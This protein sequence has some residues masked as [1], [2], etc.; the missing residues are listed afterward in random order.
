MNIGHNAFAGTAIYNDPNNWQS[1]VLYIDNCLIKAQNDLPNNYQIHSDTRLIAD[2]AFDSCQLMQSITIPKSV[3]RIGANAFNACSSLTS[4]TLPCG[5]S[6]VGQDA[7]ASCHAL[8][9]ITLN[10]ETLQEYLDSEVNP[11]LISMNITCPRQLKI[12]GSLVTDLVLPDGIR[13]V[14]DYA[15]YHC[16]ELTSLTAPKSL[17]VLGEKAFEGCANLRTS[18][19]QTIANQFVR[20]CVDGLYYQHLEGNHVEVTYQALHSP[21]NYPTLT[22]AQIPTSVTYN[23][24]SYSVTSI[25]WDAFYRC[26]SLAS[27]AVPHSVQTIQPG[28]FAA[29]PQLR[30]VILENG[31]TTI[32]Q[33]A[34]ASCPSISFINLPN[35][36]TDIHRSAFEACTSLKSIRLPERVRSIENRLFAACSSLEQITIPASVTS[37]AGSAFYDTKLYNDAQQ[38]G[39]GELYIDYCLITVN[40]LLKGKYAVHR[41][42]E[43]IANW[44]FNNCASL[45]S[46]VLPKSVTRIGS[47]AFMGCSGLKS[48]TCEAIQPPALSSV[49]FEEL[50]KTLKIYV[51]KQSL[52]R[53]KKASGWKRFQILP[54]K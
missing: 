9:S 51:P 41:H 5:I 49:A 17:Q 52:E 16:A 37:I 32:G 19:A 45:T 40:P 54:I 23:G 24:T 3:D 35:T 36:L 27:V 30:S 7:F 15:F 22:S 44:A 43:L 14:G 10:A 11:R 47:Y 29:C 46:I 38:Y 42:T 26:T 2:C 39:D 20:F 8:K 18:L 25:G 48:L 31:L 1:Q 6:Q 12:A 50:P 13:S 4:I 33:R 34:F 28:A 53:Y 21:H